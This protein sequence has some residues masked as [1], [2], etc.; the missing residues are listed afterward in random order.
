MRPSWSVWPCMLYSCARNSLTPIRPGGAST[1]G[2]TQASGRVAYRRQDKG[3]G[4]DGIVDLMGTSLGV[5]WRRMTSGLTKK[6]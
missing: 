1:V 4:W 2:E 5:G 3:K 6:R